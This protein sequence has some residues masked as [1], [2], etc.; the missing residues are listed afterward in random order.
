MASM[1][2]GDKA[3]ERASARPGVHSA[4]G[5]RATLRIL[6][7]VTAVIVLLAVAAAAAFLRYDRRT[8]WERATIASNNVARFLETDITRTLRVYDLSL[9]G[10]I[11]SLAQPQFRLL[12]PEVAHRLLFERAAMADYLGSIIVLDAKGNVVHDSRSVIAEKGNFADRD[13]FQVHR[14]SVDAGLYVSG[15]YR[16]RLRGGDPSIAIS[17]RLARPDGSFGGVVVGALRLAYLDDRFGRIALGVGDSITLSRDDGL[18]LRRR[19]GQEDAPAGVVPAQL[20]SQYAEHVSGSF[21]SDVGGTERHYSFARVTGL[22]LTV[23]IATSTEGIMRPWVHRAWFAG[24]STTA[25]CIAVVLL[26]VFFRRVMR[27][28]RSETAQLTELAQTDGL[29]GLLNRRAFDAALRK[30][31]DDA[32]VLGRPLALLFIDADNFK[33]FN[34]VHGHQAGDDLLRQLSRVARKTAR[35]PTDV[36]ARYG[37]EE[38]VVLLPD[39]D[40]RAAWRIAEDIRQAVEHLHVRN[41]GGVVT[42]SVGVASMW[43]APPYQAD[44]LVARADQ[45]LYVAKARGRNQVHAGRSLQPDTPAQRVRHGEGLQ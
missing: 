33:H 1:R 3:R 42:V 38:F 41:G 31:W 14:T 37:G 36:A 20:L 15:P 40:L 2:H 29:T 19:P 27:Q 30:A 18:V 12:S 32:M 11:D 10:V 26:M 23:S 45:A 21:I 6:M 22:P 25:F 9:Q 24:V 17:R 39:T 8:T 13:Y 35:R 34:D 28:G 4:M 5:S 44:D 43:P 16:S 7:A